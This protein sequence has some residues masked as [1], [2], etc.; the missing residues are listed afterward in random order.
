V[1]GDVAHLSDFTGALY[2]SH[3]RTSDRAGRPAAQRAA[4]NYVYTVQGNV[5]NYTSHG[6]QYSAS[7]TGRYLKVR[8]TATGKLLA[9]VFPP[10][11]YSNFSMITAR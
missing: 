6:T 4:A 3:A 5:Y 10:K 9:T 7:V 2:R 1:E 8:S 11:P